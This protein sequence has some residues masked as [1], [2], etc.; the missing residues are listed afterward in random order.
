MINDKEGKTILA[1]SDRDVREGG[2]RCVNVAEGAKVGAI[3]AQKAKEAG[4][5]KAVFDRGG[6]QYHGVI[7]AVADGARKGGLIV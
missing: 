2:T 5:T 1:V 3:L 4:V 7:R 6:Y